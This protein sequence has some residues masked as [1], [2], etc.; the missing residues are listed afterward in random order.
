MAD[1]PPD[2]LTLPCK[3]A[4][5]TQTPRTW[6]V[7]DGMSKVISG[8]VL[9]RGDFSAYGVKSNQHLVQAI[10]TSPDPL[11]RI[12]VSPFFVTLDRRKPV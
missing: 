11:I 3:V 9:M 2:Q 7:T 12:P 4:Q 10:S 8:Q 6:G 1:L 5:T